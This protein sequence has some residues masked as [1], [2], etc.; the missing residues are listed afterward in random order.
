MRP[1]TE[2]HLEIPVSW[3]ERSKNPSTGKD[4]ALHPRRFGS[5]VATRAH[6]PPTHA[7]GPRRRRQSPELDRA[8]TGALR[9]SWLSRVQEKQNRNTNTSTS[10]GFLGFATRG[11]LGLL[12]S[13]EH[14]GRTLP[15]EISASWTWTTAA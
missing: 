14:R 15:P 7:N 8:T 1:K 5:I 4:G 10:L 13:V 12:Y 6:P 3:A 11:V 2:V 9:L